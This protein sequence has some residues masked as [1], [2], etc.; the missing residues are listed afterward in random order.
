M[1]PEITQEQQD[2]WQYYDYY[3]SQY[4]AIIQGIKE[5]DDE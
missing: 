2:E 4:E 5:K 1:E 3:A